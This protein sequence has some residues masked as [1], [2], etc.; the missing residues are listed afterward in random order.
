VP[1]VLLDGIT[2]WLGIEYFPEFVQP[3]LKSKQKEWNA[4]EAVQGTEAEGNIQS[5]SSLY[6]G[7]RSIST[8][9]GS[10]LCGNAQFPVRKFETY[11]SRSF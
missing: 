8:I 6:D 4:E 9:L 10:G 3:H 11:V 7:S 5:A 1:C 2:D